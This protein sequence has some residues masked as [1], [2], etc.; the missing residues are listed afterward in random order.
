M[1]KLYEIIIIIITNHIKYKL[2]NIFKKIIYI[3][4]LSFLNRYV[5]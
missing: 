5:E 4:F 1:L 3:L 2:Y